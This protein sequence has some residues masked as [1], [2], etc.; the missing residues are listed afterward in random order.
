[1]FYLKIQSNRVFVYS[2]CF[3]CIFQKHAIKAIF[4]RQPTGKKLISIGVC[5][6]W[7]LEYVLVLLCIFQFWMLNLKIQSN[8]AFVYSSVA[9]FKS[10]QSKP[11]FFGS[12]LS[13]ESVKG[14]ENFP[15]SIFCRQRP[16]SLLFWFGYCA[17]IS[18]L[19]SKYFCS[20][21]WLHNFHIMVVK[22]FIQ[23][24]SNT[25]SGLIK[26]K[27]YQISHKEFCD[28]RIKKALN[29]TMNA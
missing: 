8:R 14:S 15:P 13:N 16:R 18:T 26:T 1:M 5:L 21:V 24:R 17:T 19:G 7:T 27:H 12:Q 28:T 29:Y 3:C 22:V 11:S 23:K 4:F 2:C 20:L 10:M 25:W 6:F 9:Y